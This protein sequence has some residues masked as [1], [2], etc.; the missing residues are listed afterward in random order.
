MASLGDKNRH[1]MRP[2]YRTDVRDFLALRGERSS[3][4]NVF[5]LFLQTE[6]PARGRVEYDQASSQDGFDAKPSSQSSTSAKASSLA[7]LA[8]SPYPLPASTH[9]S[10][11]R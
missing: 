1:E 9:E 4:G 3:G 10:D 8:D 7:S 5:H 2:A 11:E 6:N